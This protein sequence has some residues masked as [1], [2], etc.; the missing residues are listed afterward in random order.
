V[1][2]GAGPNFF[3][4]LQI[5][6]LAG[7]EFTDR[8][9]VGTPAVAIVNEAYAERYFGTRNPVGQ[10]LSASVSRRREDL[11]IVG[12]AK[13]TR[14]AGLRA[15]PPATVYVAYYQ[16]TTGSRTTLSVRAAGSMV[17]VSRALQQTLQPKY[18]AASIEV[19]PLSSQVADTIVQERMMATL[20]GGFAMLALALACIGIYG[21]LAYNVSRQTREIG[22][23]MAL[24]AQA[25]RVIALVVAVG[26]RL[27]LIGV[28]A[29]LPVVWIG[30]RWIESLLF[31][32]R[33]LDPMTIAGAVAVLL[34]AAQLASYLPARRASR[35]DPLEALRHD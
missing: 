27:V 8:D 18:P 3:S 1:F 26:T 10:H 12:L 15:E 24:G 23:R 28:V 7:R 22:I 33:P 34:I 31:E 16:L 4:T 6:L 14:L 29:G 20:A 32:V 30:S 11:E 25:G 21:L 19:R 5:P 17:Q 13:N 9:R 2:V 35:V